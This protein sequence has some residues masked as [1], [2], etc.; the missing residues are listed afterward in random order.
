M[1]IKKLYLYITVFLCFFYLG[2]ADNGHIV[3]VQGKILEEGTNKPVS[4]IIAF[5]NQSGKMT[6]CKSNSND[7]SYQ[8]VLHSGNFYT[9]FLKNYFIKNG[10]NTLDIPSNSKYKEVTT[11]FS[12]NSFKSGAKIQLAA[13]KAYEPNKAEL[14]PTI[15]SDLTPLKYFLNLNPGIKLQVK[16]SSYDSWFKSTRKKI[17]KTNRRGKKY[18]KRVRYS[19]KQQLSDLLDN[20]LKT[21][22]NYFKKK[23]IYLKDKA[24]VKELKVI[25]P[26]KKRKRRLKKG[27]TKRR[28]R[29]EYYTPKYPNVFL[30]I[31]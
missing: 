10:S 18:F 28:K 11:K 3:L 17:Q 12:V 24:F 9:I 22:K 25:S 14:L 6:Q 4:T 19:T 26:R 21:I 23:H 7:G 30:I 15:S 2:F 1:Q 16:I 13:F 8:Q 27:S 31:N 5:V 29:Y 20:R